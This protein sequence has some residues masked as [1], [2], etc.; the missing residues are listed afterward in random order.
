MELVPIEQGLARVLGGRIAHDDEIG[1]RYALSDD[2][3][4]R[5]KLPFAPFLTA[6]GEEC[7]GIGPLVTVLD[8]ACGIGAMLAMGF[9][10]GTATV[11][12]RVDYLRAPSAGASCMVTAMPVDVG[13]QPE[14]G[15]VMMHAEAREMTGGDVLAHATGRFIRRRLPAPGKAPSLPPALSKPTAADYPA[16]MGFA[17]EGAGLRMPFRPGLVG[18]GSLPSLHG[19]AVAA[20]LQQAACSALAVE[21]R[22]PA[23]LVTG[24]FSFLRFAGAADTLASAVI[25]RRGASVASVEAAS[26]QE[27]GRATARGVFTFAW[28]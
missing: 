24:H 19:G 25:E 28:M 2:G 9:R 27:P 26:W 18:N 1:V 17:P 15:M 23:R 16:L 20:H 22:R 10:E 6:A 14:A 8:S 12:L 3:R 5:L 7:I 4:A 11:D 21:S 13:G